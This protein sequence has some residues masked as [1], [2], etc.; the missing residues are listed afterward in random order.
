MPASKRRRVGTPKQVAHSP[1]AAAP[2]ENRVKQELTVGV[3]RRL[4]LGENE[5]VPAEIQGLVDSAAREV[6]GNSVA[7]AVV[8][9]VSNLRPSSFSATS[10]SEAAPMSSDVA[11]LREAEHLA[12]KKNALLVAGFANDEAMRI[13]VAEVTGRAS[14]IES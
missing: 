2:M 8:R 10:G 3:K 11:L 12:A 4:G 9:E 14:R 5:R 6:V 13:L 7:T 1:A